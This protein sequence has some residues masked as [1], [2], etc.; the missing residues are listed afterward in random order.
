MV[1]FLKFLSSERCMS[2]RKRM[3]RSSHL[4]M[5]LPRARERRL[6]R[7]AEEDA[8]DH[9]GALQ[10]ERRREAVQA[11]QRHDVVGAPRVF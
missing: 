5:T 2:I 10:R 1:V 8:L 9:G 11:P 3:V 4:K 7:V 6:Q